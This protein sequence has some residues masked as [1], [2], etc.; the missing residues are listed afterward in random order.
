L[1]TL[2]FFNKYSFFFI[3]VLGAHCS[4]YKSSFSISNISCWIHPLH[5]SPLSPLPLLFLSVNTTC[6]NVCAEFNEEF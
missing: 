1:K 5:H 4:I 3:V 2:F 6:I